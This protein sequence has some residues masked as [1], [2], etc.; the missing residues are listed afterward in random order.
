MTQFL[1][2]SDLRGYESPRPA[3]GHVEIIFSFHNETRVP[4]RASDG[5]NTWN[6]SVPHWPEFQHHLFC[7]LIPQCRNGQ[8][9]A[10]CPYASPECD[11]GYL[12]VNGS[13][14]QVTQMLWSMLLILLLLPLLLLLLLLLRRR[15]RLNR[16]FWLVGWLVGRTH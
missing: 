5:T 11:D 4:E 10:S 12:H 1:S 2:C 7:D 14:Y 15:R 8:D 9:E 13:C 6:C 16:R 3:T